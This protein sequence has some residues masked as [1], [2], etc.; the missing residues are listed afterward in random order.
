MSSVRII[1]LLWGIGFVFL[2]IVI[3]RHL[4]IYGAEPDVVLIFLIWLTTRRER[5]TCLLYA[6]G[7]GFL[8][9][10]MLDLWGL[11][12]FSKTLLVMVIF[13]FLPKKT[14]TRLSVWQVFLTVLIASLIHYLIFMSLGFLVET[15]ATDSYF[16]TYWLGNSIYTA[17]I[18]SLIY[19]LTSD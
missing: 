17:V 5:T 8:Q 7:L 1:H 13:R 19:L 3:F 14:E 9:D 2:Q 4:S 10:A 12:I 6:A 15:Y 11:H 18:G 16:L